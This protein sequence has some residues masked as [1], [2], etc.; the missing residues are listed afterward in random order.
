MNKR[1]WV[2]LLLPVL[3]C[4]G[5]SAGVWL[6]L[7][8]QIDLNPAQ[9]LETAQA[10]WQDAAIGDY[11]AWVQVEAPYATSGVYA[12]TVE[13]N[14]LVSAQVY[15]PLTFRY[16]PNAPSFEVSFSQASAYTVDSLLNRA[17][18]LTDDLQRFHVHTPTTNHVTFD[19]RYGYV[20]RYVNNTCGLALSMIEQCLTQIEV[21]RFEVIEQ[22]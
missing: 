20:A 7:D 19:P 9:Q 14:E 21:L 6:W 13:G 2:W 12:L 10:H 5:V 1:H 4:G 3:L 11:R 17:S 8:V 22:E 16:D 18:R 15:N